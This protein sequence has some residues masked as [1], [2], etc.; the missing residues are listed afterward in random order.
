[1]LLVVVNILTFD[2]FSVELSDV[3]VAL[4]S[5]LGNGKTF[6]VVGVVR[7]RNVIRHKSTI[8]LLGRTKLA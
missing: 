3:G 2:F 7:T 6:C 5:L 1:M 4:H 8:A